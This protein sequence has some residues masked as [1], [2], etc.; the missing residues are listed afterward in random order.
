MHAINA[1]I[2]LQYLK[3]NNLLARDFWEEGTVSV[4]VWKVSVLG[5]FEALR[6]DLH[7][8]L[9]VGSNFLCRWNSTEAS[10]HSFSS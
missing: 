2:H 5:L 9:L 4:S 7:N 3:E 1:H 10:W 6:P 8:L